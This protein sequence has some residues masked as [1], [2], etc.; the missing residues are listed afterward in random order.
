MQID[1]AIR[2]TRRAA[3]DARDLAKRQ[4]CAGLRD[5][6]KIEAEKARAFE[7]VCDGLEIARD[8]INGL[9][10]PPNSPGDGRKSAGKV[11]PLPDARNASEGK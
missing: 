6:A 1:E 11:N 9:K 7:T 5:F 8:A 10:F 2:I 4:R 3:E